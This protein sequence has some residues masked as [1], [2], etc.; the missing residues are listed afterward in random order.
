M[1]TTVVATIIEA[2][3]AAIAEVATEQM[4]ILVLSIGGCPG[5]FLTPSEIWT[6]S[7]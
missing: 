7:S 1:A 6:D 2:I 5:R 3:A 4:C